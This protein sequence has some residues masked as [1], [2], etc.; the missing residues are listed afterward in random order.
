MRIDDYVGELERALTGPYGP[1]HDLLVEARD[2]LAD[3]ADA[4]EAGGLDRAEAERLAVAGFGAVEEVAPGY[5]AELTAA[6]GR[7]LGMLLVAGIPV[8]VLMWSVVWRFYPTDRAALTGWPV[9]LSR[10][11]DLAQLATSLYGGLVLFA[12]GRGARWVRGPQA[13]TRSLGVLVW[14]M[15]PATGLMTLPLALDGRMG[16]LPDFLPAMVAGLATA[17]F[18]GVQVF[19]ATRCLRVTSPRRHRGRG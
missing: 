8:T 2:S 1:K 10:A 19:G 13:V 11:L 18:W 14:V 9:A 15:L 4:L 6:A 7:R 3:T 17:A 5:Q 12:L 16:A